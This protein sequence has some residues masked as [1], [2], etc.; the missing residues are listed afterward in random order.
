MSMTIAYWCLLIAALMPYL[1]VAVAKANGKRYDNRDPRAWQARQDSPRSN[2]AYAAHLN[3]FEAFAPFA[4]GVLAAQMAGV[5]T[6][7]I[8]ILSIVF[9]VCRVLHGVFYIA[10][11]APLRSLVWAIGFLCAMALLALAALASI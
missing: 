2:A 8:V 3:A 7:W 9:V 6:D 1:W 11:K 4:A 10:G 5:D